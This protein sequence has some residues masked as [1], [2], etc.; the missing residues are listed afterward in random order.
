MD[1]IPTH[2]F[3]DNSP[4]V[5]VGAILLLAFAA[6]ALFGPGEA[7]GPGSEQ[8]EI[9]GDPP[10]EALPASPEEDSTVLSL[11]DP[12]EAKLRNAA[13]PVAEDALSPTTPFAFRGSSADR[14]RARDCLA[15]AAIAEAGSGDADQRAVMQVVLNRTRHPAFANTVCGVVFEGSQRPTG[16]QFT[17]TCD[18]SLARSYS[19]ELWRAA[20]ARAD[21]ALGGYVHKPVGTATH[22]HA[23]YVY[24]YWSSSLD[25]VAT[26]G[27]HL[28]FRWKGGWGTARA[29]TSRYR[30]GEPDPMA[31]RQTAQE[32]DRPEEV[33]TLAE[34]GEAVRTITATGE[35]ESEG[36]A[37][38]DAQAPTVQPL[39]SS[40]TPQAGVHFVVVSAGND[41]ATLVARSRAL[42]PGEKYCQIYGWSDPGA[43]PAKLPLGDEQRATLAYAFLAARNGNPEVIYFDCRQFPEPALGRCL[44]RPKP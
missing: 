13:I 10:V 41:P 21:D 4:L 44:P 3:R 33:L 7:D 38:A 43:I 40:A 37:L 39:S 1:G 31:L 34:S 32:V 6:L 22:Y 18:G 5:G 36:S 19:A 29:L 27:P 24:P 35:I 16:C 25:K 8:V 30:G 17:F 2:W 42:C 14:T 23:D 15:L 20:R 28:F 26:I 12:E 9:V 11:L